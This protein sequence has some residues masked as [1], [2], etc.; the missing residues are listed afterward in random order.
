MWVIKTKEKLARFFGNF[1]ERQL[2]KMATKKQLIKSINSCF[3]VEITFLFPNHFI[4]TVMSFN[5]SIFWG[6]SYPLPYHLEH[7]HKPAKQSWK[8]LHPDFVLPFLFPLLE[9]QENELFCSRFLSYRI[10][11]EM[12]YSNTSHTYNSIANLT[13]NQH[14]IQQCKLYCI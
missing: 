6:R 4:F 14:L 9:Q 5:D 8:M 2:A 1:F 13:I 7:I 11:I 3:V 10:L 12:P